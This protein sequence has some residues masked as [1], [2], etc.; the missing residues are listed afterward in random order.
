MEAY[1]YLLDRSLH[2]E[3]L[4]EIIKKNGNIDFPKNQDNLF[5]FLV[6]LVIKQQ[7]SNNVAEKIWGRLIKYSSGNVFDFINSERSDILSLCGIS[8]Q[9]KLSIIRLK[10]KFSVQDF[11]KNLFL[12]STV[13]IKNKIIS[14]YGFGEWSADMVCIFYLKNPDIWA[15][16]DSTLKKMKQYFNLSEEFIELCS[17]YRSY[18]SLHLWKAVDDKLII[19][20][21]KI[22]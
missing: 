20:S 4:Y 10:E 5:D 9:K 16:Q 14:W 21:N 7:L 1:T 22:L 13:E 12:G 2:N 15:V 6:K 19:F 3:K 11:D 18:L 8:N 17:P